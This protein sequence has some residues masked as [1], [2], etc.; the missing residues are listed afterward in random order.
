M[1]MTGLIVKSLRQTEEQKEHGGWN[2]PL[3][4]SGARVVAIEHTESKQYFAHAFTS[5]MSA[6]NKLIEL[7]EM[8][9]S[10]QEALQTFMKLNFTP[11]PKAVVD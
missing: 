6:M 7:A 1:K 11:Q 4:K 8:D 10:S 9:F 5:S 2:R 3:V